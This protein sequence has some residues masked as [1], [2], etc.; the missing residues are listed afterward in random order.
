MKTLSIIGSTGSVGT[1]AVDLALHKGWDVAALAC[2][3]NI[4]TAEQQIRALRPRY[5][6]V[7]D[8][9][10]ARTLRGRVADVGCAVEGGQEAVLRA[11]SFEESDMVLNAATGIAGLRPTLAALNSCKALALANKESMVCAGNVVTSLAR[12]KNVPILPVDSEH[13]A[14]FQCLRAG[15]KGEVDRLILTASGGP[16]FGW[17]RERL[18]TVTAA[19]ALR[20]PTWTMGQKITIDS[21]TMMN[22]GFEVLEASWLFGVPTECIDVVVHRESIV[23]SAVKFVDG[24]IIAQMGSADMRL[25]IQVAVDHPHRT[26]NPFKTLDIFSLSGLS[27]YRPDREAFPCLTLCESARGNTGAVINGANEVAV[28]AFLQGRIGFN[29]IYRIAREAV[30][31]CDLIADPDLEQVFDSDRKAREAARAFLARKGV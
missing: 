23:H 21:A 3:H 16:F 30:E 7:M 11:A 1:Q 12:E 5:C 29:D 17:D 25:P 19:D 13:S 26:E 28:A 9:D 2:G 31:T 22:K 15:E 4:E 10:A 18:E 20:H 6:A 8:E 24:S 14:I 27:F